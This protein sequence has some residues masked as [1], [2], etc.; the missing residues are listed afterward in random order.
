MDQLVSPARRAAGRTKRASRYAW[1]TRISAARLQR[2]DD[3]PIPPRVEEVRLFAKVR[4]ESV[5][6][7]YF[8]EYYTALG[9]D[10]FFLVDNGSDDKTGETALNWDKVHVF[11]TDE[12][13]GNYERWLNILLQK[14]GR[15]GWCVTADADEFLVL[16]TQGDQ[17]ID[18]AIEDLEDNGETALMCLL[19][20]M[21]PEGPLKTHDPYTSGADP[22]LFAP[23]FDPEFTEA[24]VN[25]ENRRTGRPFVSPRF[26]GG[27]RERLFDLDMNLTK[28]ALFTVDSQ[29]WLGDGAHSVYSPRISSGRGVM[30]HMKH[31]PGLTD[32]IIS[33]TAR[34]EHAGGS[35]YLRPVAERLDSSESMR[36]DYPGSVR[37]TGVQQLFELGLSRPI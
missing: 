14:Y 21:Y 37:F 8:L 30:L 3:R 27:M 35:S 19:L 17:R 11:S 5:R 22:M 2:L 4:N 1:D 10:R 32:R 31:L 25:V 36:F 20:D 16:P 24:E 33:D 26:T 18:I 34:G 12:R 29:T 15:N 28:A 6:L 7:P 9:V 13:F 23:L